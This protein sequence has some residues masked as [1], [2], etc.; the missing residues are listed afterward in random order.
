MEQERQ[1]APE[2]LGAVLVFLNAVGGTIDEWNQTRNEPEQEE[3]KKLVSL[4]MLSGYYRHLQYL[5]LLRQIACFEKLIKTYKADKV[6]PALRALLEVAPPKWDTLPGNKEKPWNQVIYDMIQEGK[7][8]FTPFKGQSKAENWLLTYR[9]ASTPLPHIETDLN[10]LAAELP[11]RKAETI[12]ILTNSIKL[13]LADDVN[14]VAETNI[15]GLLDIIESRY[16]TY[17]ASRY[18]LKH[19]SIAK[20]KTPES[21]DFYLNPATGQITDL[22]PYAAEIEKLLSPV[23]WD[24]LKQFVDTGRNAIRKYHKENEPTPE[25]LPAILDQAFTKMLNTPPTNDLMKI[26]TAVVGRGG[27][28]NQYLS[29]NLFTKQWEGKINKT[30]IIYGEEG[31]NLATPVFTGSTWK[32]LIIAMIL[33]TAQ[34]TKGGDELNLGISGTVD[35]YLKLT[36]RAVTLSNRKEVS[37]T[38][39]RDLLTL[40]R[41]SIKYNDKKYSLDM[42][43]LFGRVKLSRGKFEMEFTET[44]GRYASK[45]TSYITKYF[46]MSIL[47]LKEK[48]PSLITLSV[49]LAILRNMDRN[50]EKGRATISSINSLLAYCP[51]LPT[52]E[53]VRKWGGSPYNKIVKPFEETIMDQLVEQGVLQYWEYC[54]EKGEPLKKADVDSYNYFVKI[55]VKYEFTGYPI[56]AE[57]E[58]ELPRIEAKQEKARKRAERRERETDKAI[59]RQQAKKILQQD[60]K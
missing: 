10:T 16:K 14:M 25:P 59:A 19:G 13:E 28:S 44:F 41:T 40:G 51:G 46:P 57:I 48:N 35:D 32:L 24:F 1:Q 39:K 2:K 5:K 17:K 55:Y 12:A 43:N 56:D 23:S 6:S 20:T 45:T 29:Q 36:G 7:A 49:H 53:Q 15:N 38:L 37:K 50:R 52:I 31:G 18:S 34:N 22:R 47:K 42:V 30:E 8:D 9:I 21:Y 3:I 54:L 26:N 11:G 58:T 60:K 27:N 4:G 33:F